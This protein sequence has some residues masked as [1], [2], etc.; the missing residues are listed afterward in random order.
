MRRH[1]CVELAGAGVAGRSW[2]P[3]STWIALAGSYSASKAALFSQTNSLRLELKPRGIDVTGLHVGYVEADLAARVN[4][5]KT[6][7]EN[8][9]GQALDAIEAGA[10]EVLVD[11][12]SRHVKAGLAAHPAACTRSWLSEERGQSHLGPFV[13][14]RCHLAGPVER[15]RVRRRFIVVV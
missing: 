9:A 3:A 15:R 14:E 6:S 13:E 8:A 7:P 4:S 2:P 1:G 12:R 10:Y 5:P 11:E